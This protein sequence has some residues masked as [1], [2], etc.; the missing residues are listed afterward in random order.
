M[1]VNPWFRAPNLPQS[2]EWGGTRHLC[3]LLGSTVLSETDLAPAT[4]PA[5]H[6]TPFG[7]PKRKSSNAGPWVHTHG[8]LVPPRSGF[9]TECTWTL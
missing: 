5:P 9:K 8:Y 4:L 2:P 7:V 1:G 6:A 3:R